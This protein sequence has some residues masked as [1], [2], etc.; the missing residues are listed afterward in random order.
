MVDVVRYNE[1][2]MDTWDNFVYSSRNGTLFHTQK[3]LSYHKNKFTDNSLIFKYKGEIAAVLP[4]ILD[5]S[6]TLFSHA[7][8][9][10]GGLVLRKNAGLGITYAIVNEIIDHCSKN[11][12]KR[13]MMRLPPYI[14]HKIPCDE[15]DFSLTALDFKVSSYDL[16]CVITLD[17]SII[18]SDSTARAIR[19]AIE[20]GLWVSYDSVEWEKYW[21]I[22][23]S[24]LSDKHDVQPT[25]TLDEML[26]IKNMFPDKIKLITCHLKDKMI[27]GVVL[28]IGND[29]AFEVFYIA[30]NYEY[31]EYRALNLVLHNVISWGFMNRFKYMNLGISTEDHGTKV[32]W[33]LFKFKEGFGSH[34]V[35]RRTYRRDL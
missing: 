6:D 30:Q 22:L 11:S 32:N 17:S 2:N 33:G 8:S 3:F 19:K 10:F 13:I 31:Q 20:G 28:F 15:L 5:E 27:C 14:Y 34:S 26:R 35:L 25:H 23:E 21:K 1:R 7:G 4:A 24:N 18:I 29:N 16:S 9:S 12:V